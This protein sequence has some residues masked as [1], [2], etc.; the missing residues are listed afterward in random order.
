MIQAYE[1]ELFNKDSRILAAQKE[2]KVLEKQ[3]A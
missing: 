1:E 2:V 3:N